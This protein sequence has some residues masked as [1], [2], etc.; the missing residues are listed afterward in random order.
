MRRF[1]AFLLCALLTLSATAQTVSFEGVQQDI[2]VDVR[3]TVEYQNGHI[4]GAINVPLNQIEAGM[5]PLQHLN[6]NSKVLVYCR[7]GRRSAL[8][9]DALI[10][11]GF[12]YVYDGGGMQELAAKLKICSTKHC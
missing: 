6:K 9:R 10:K 8:A 1:F 7:S 3:T 5:A 2:L 11:R 4:A 12:R